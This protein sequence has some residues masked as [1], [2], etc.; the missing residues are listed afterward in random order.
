[1]RYPHDAS[2]HLA[3]HRCGAGS[4]QGLG[5]GRMCEGVSGGGGGLV[6]GWDKAIHPQVAVADGPLLT[7]GCVD[8]VGKLALT[9]SHDEARLAHR[10]VPCQHQLVHPL[11]LAND[12]PLKR[13]NQQRWLAV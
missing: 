3:S 10:S 11:G 2:D 6:A 13:T 8:V 7:E 12:W 1:M 9:K 4:V 5:I